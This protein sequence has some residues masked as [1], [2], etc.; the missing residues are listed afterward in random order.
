M[1]KTKS[2]FTPRK[3]QKCESGR[4][5][6]KKYS[7]KGHLQTPS[8]LPN[9]PCP[10]PIIT[11]CTQLKVLIYRQ[12]ELQKQQSRLISRAAA[13]IKQVVRAADCA[14]AVIV[15]MRMDG[16]A[17]RDRATGPSSVIEKI[18]YW[19]FLSKQLN[20]EVT[21]RKSNQATCCS[22]VYADQCEHRVCQQEESN[23][24]HV[25]SNEDCI[26]IIYLLLM[27]FADD[28]IK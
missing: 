5:S 12:H 11:Y 6:L 14:G 27:K 28:E 24:L 26:V 17:P 22:N 4:H 8:L 20:S 3:Y 19:T 16:R 21:G 2:K 10:F 25:G 1:K 23:V 18:I 13:L 9:K 15:L 7:E